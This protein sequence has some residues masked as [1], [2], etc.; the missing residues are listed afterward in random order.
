VFYHCTLARQIQVM[1]VVNLDTLKYIR[2]ASGRIQDD[3]ASTVRNETVPPPA[4][5][6]RMVVTAQG[7]SS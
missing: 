1:D 6:A 7:K 5:V 2:P 4:I 3:A